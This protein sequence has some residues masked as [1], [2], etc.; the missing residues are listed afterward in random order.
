M[1]ETP[2]KTRRA[3]S[4]L[5]QTSQPLEASDVEN[6]SG[7]AAE[8]TARSRT[9]RRRTAKFT[10]NLDD[11]DVKVT[12]NGD[13]NDHRISSK[14]SSDIPVKA[15]GTSTDAHVVDGWSPGQDPKID[16]SGEFEFGGSFGT[17]CMMIFFPILMW[18]MWIGA[19][20]YDGKLPSRAAGQSW[21]DFGHHL[22]DL[23]YTG[24]FP[25]TK[26]WLWYWS[27]FIFEGALYCL[28]PGVWGH[29]K[30]LP[31]MDNKQ[32]PYFCNAYASLYFTLTVLAGLHF[33]GLWPLYTAIDEFGS[34]M[35][36]AI[37]TGYIVSIIAYFSAI[38]RGQQHRMTGHFIYDFF[39]GAELNPRMFGILDFKMFFE[40][41]MPWFILLILSLGAAA[42]QYETYGYVS[43]EVMFLVMAHY[44][45]ANA[46][47]KGEELIITTW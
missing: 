33:S 25:H 34:L 16:Y 17:G 14:G 1:V 41:R 32:L 4:R 24:A 38:W 9:S 26:A 43:G 2:A 36:V 44:L 19:T 42:R 23:V 6:D 30:Q 11:E 45:Y 15:E 28:L 22:V 7:S 47:A 39:M 10:E 18:Y 46:C 12:T 27:Y 37:I 5:R 3:S 31:H 35:S 8:T 20:Y 21:A 13:S 40:V 29:G